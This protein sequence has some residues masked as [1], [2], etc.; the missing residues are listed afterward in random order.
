MAK[1][2]LDDGVQNGDGKGLGQECLYREVLELLRQIRIGGDDED[3]CMVELGKGANMPDELN[4]AHNRHV[5]VGDDEIELTS[6]DEV[7]GFKYIGRG[8]ELILA[9][10]GVSQK[11]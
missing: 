6:A 2:G 9:R 10:K 1:E 8:M 7:R 11:L 5:K 4:A 3:R